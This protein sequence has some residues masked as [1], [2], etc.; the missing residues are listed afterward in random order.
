MI[1]ATIKVRVNSRLRWIGTVHR[2]KLEGVK[3]FS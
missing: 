2:N 3:I 1:M